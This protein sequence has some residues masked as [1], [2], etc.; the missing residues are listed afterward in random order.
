MSE[1]GDYTSTSWVSTH[2]FGSARSAYMDSV[3]NRSYS[4][5]TAASVAAKDLVEPNISIENPALVIVS[6][7]TG[8]MGQWPAIMFS[9]LPYLLHELKVYLGEDA[10][11]IIAAVGDATCDNYPL[12]MQLPKRTY[13]EA[14]E[15]FSKLVVEGGGGGQK[16]ESY[17]LAAGYLL[18]AVKVRTG[19]QKPI[20][21]FIGD[22]SPYSMVDSNQL[23]NFGISVE[24]Q[25]TQEVFNQLNKIYDV[26]LIQKPY[27]ATGGM[28]TAQV[29]ASWTPL[30]PPE[31]IIP[32][33]QP[34]RV[35]DV[36]FGI[37]AN[38]TNK[39][40]YFKGEITDRQNPDQVVTVLTSLHGLYSK[41]ITTID[42]TPATGAK[43]PKTGGKST[44][45][46]LPP[47][48]PAKPLI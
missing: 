25:S 13:E 31:H 19:I 8:S 41:N 12:Q 46:K 47:G 36:M 20:L 39:V 15:G 10:S 28:Q 16:T 6:D 48:K 35:V 34:E 29:K 22:E 27:D 14:N 33:N 1:S 3:V 32:L 45:H 2:D 38:A 40:D 18:H 37:L 9:K 42:S 23:A 11:V 30:L 24:T 44:M 43:P 5:A 7:V 26:Y 4:K 21:I 17:E